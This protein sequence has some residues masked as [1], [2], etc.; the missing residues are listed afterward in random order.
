LLFSAAFLAFAFSFFFCPFVNFFTAAAVEAAD[1]P[2]PAE[3]PCRCCASLRFL[4]ISSLSFLT[5]AS[6]YT[7]PAS[8]KF[9]G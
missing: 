1:R 3:V 4:T 7:S 9:S 5:F 6:S 2:L 8:R